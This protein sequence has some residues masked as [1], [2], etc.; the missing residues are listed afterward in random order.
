MVCESEFEHQTEPM[1]TMDAEYE[2]NTRVKKR[3]LNEH[4][5]MPLVVHNESLINLSKTYQ[6]VEV[7]IPRNVLK[8]LNKFVTIESNQT[9]SNGSQA[10]FVLKNQKNR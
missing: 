8:I 9:A 6:H 1:D 4:Q 10:L 7:P 3:K 5:E 2:S